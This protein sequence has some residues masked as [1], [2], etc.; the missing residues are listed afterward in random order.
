MAQLRHGPPVFHSGW[1]FKEGTDGDLWKRFLRLSGTAL[2][3]S[4]SEMSQPS[5]HI[6]LLDTPVTGGPRPLEIQIHLRRRTLS[7]FAQTDGDYYAWLQA[8]GRAMEM[9]ID[10]F[11]DIGHVLGQ[12]SFATV[13]MARDR[14]TNQQFAIKII[15]K[16]M[17]KPDELQWLMREVKIMM[18]VQHDHI[19]DTYDIFDSKRHLHL[20]IEYMA[21]GELF[22]IIADQ[23]HLSEQTASIVMREIIK[24][25]EYLHDVGVVHCDIK[26]ENIL[27]K[28][29]QWPYSVKLCDFGLANFF[30]Q[31]NNNTMTETIG[32]PGYVA[33]EVVRREPYGP[34]VDMWACGVVL[35]VMLSGRMPFYGKDD[36]QCLRRTAAGE[37]SFPEREWKHVS[38]R[39]ISLVRSL[40]Q[41]RPELRLTAKAALQ[42]D[43][44]AQPETL[45]TAPLHNDLSQIHSRVRQRF[46]KAVTIARTI[47]RMKD[48]I[49]GM[50][51]VPG[52]NNTDVDT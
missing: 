21:G 32:T 13:R 17:Y 22:D 37:Y 18:N 12:G 45:N 4:H 41:I 35:Y 16:D 30:D 36:V 24:G 39:A 40:L 28:S 51:R 27:C 43:W 8:F 34:P 48:L 33:P 44:V 19:V 9:R 10:K 5:W 2:S 3:N 29:K 20:V 23:G 31:Y 1:L 25:V 6:S 26:P 14:G 46:R 49:G 38:D 42:H 7:Y 11:Y 15:H 52:A 50:S 47:E